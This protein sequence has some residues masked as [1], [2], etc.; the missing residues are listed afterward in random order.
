MEEME[1]FSMVLLVRVTRASA[2]RGS[3]H[4]LEAIRSPSMPATPT[5]EELLE[6]QEKWNATISVAL[7]AEVAKERAKGIS[8]WSTVFGQRNRPMMSTELMIAA[9]GPDC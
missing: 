7:L 6:V 3:M 4:R 8:P 5:K 9:I 1:D 2:S